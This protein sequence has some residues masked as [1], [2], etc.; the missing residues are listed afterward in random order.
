[1]TTAPLTAQ[2]LT[3]NE[4]NEKVRN[5]L[6]NNPEII[7]EAMELLGEQEAE[8]QMAERVAPVYEELVE[9]D[10]DLVIGHKDA[11]I[12]LIEFFD[13]RCAVCKSIVPTLEAF[14]KANP[15][16]AIIKKHLPILTPS[17]ERASRYVLATNMIYGSE[18]YGQMHNALYATRR[19][20]NEATFEKAANELGL[21]HNKI[22]DKYDE[23]VITQII[24]TNR[25]IAIE[26]EIRGTPAFLTASK[27]KIGNVDGKTLSELADMT[28]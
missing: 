22:M 24:N 23:D 2:S 15:N 11:K 17:S 19:P 4:F 26:L 9:N 21:D 3:E 8:R 5:Y 6:L 1:M 10:T 27:L 13:Y 14:V 7:L 20:F 25:D 18:S 28:N 12:K 16:V